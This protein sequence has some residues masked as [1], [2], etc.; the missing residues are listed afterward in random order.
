MTGFVLLTAGIGV[1]LGL[2]RLRVTVLAPAVLFIWIGAW[3]ATEGG[4]WSQLLTGVFAS[5]AVQ[6]G[7]FVAVG[8]RYPRKTLALPGK[9]SVF[10]PSR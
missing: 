5:I 6:V 8:K 4:V 10:S 3:M 1:L 9:S 2:A 7:Y